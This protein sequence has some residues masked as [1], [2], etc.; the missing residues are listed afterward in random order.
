MTGAN[1]SKIIRQLKIYLNILTTTFHGPEELMERFG[2]S[3]R[4]LQRDLKDLRDAGVLRLKLIR[5]EK[6]YIDAEKPPVF[7]ETSTGRHR[8]HLLR[9]RRLTTLI[10]QL[11]RTDLQELQCYESELEEYELHKEYMADD[12]VTFPPDELPPAPKKPVPADIKASYYTLFPNS[13]ERMRQ[14]D[15]RALTEA[16]F[17]IF[18]DR[19]YKAF[20]CEGYEEPDW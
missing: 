15:F 11:E 12:P 17:V 6:N 14:R 1:D 19:K 8:Q 10:D 16:G 13:N 18:Y 3:R 7:D 2:I 4:M 5:K 20:I 9:L